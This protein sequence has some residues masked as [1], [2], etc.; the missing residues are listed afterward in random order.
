MP[1]AW[2]TAKIGVDVSVDGVNWVTA[3]DNAGNYEQTA[4]QASAFI[5]IPLADAIFAP[6]LRLKSVD[7]SNVAVNQTAARTL[8]VITKRYLGGSS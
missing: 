3:Y 7:A 6:F 8:T 1:A 2:T 5:C 4:A